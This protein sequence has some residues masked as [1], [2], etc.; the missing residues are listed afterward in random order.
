MLSIIHPEVYKAHLL[1][2][3]EMHGMRNC[4]A[5]PEFTEAVFEDGQSPFSAFAIIAN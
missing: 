5:D 1:V 3:L 2:L 4:L